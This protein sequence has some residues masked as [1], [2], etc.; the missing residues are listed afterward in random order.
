MTAPYGLDHPR[1]G[2]WMR[3]VQALEAG[4]VWIN[5]WGAISSMT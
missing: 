4:N 1:R 3:A 2:S 5:T